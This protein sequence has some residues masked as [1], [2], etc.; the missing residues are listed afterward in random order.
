MVRASEHGDTVCCAMHGPQVAPHAAYLLA[1]GTEAALETPAVL[2][3]GSGGRPAGVGCGRA[4]AACLA[5]AATAGAP[6]WIALM[7]ALRECSSA[8]RVFS[9]RISS[10]WRA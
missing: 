10:S 9:S 2:V 5:V 4:P 7:L 3:G 1:S 6:C 8:W